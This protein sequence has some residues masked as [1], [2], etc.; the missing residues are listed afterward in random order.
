[1]LSW[2]V[3]YRASFAIDLLFGLRYEHRKNVDPPQS[4][5]ARYTLFPV[6]PFDIL[7]G[8]YRASVFS[9]EFSPTISGAFF[10]NV[11]RRG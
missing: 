10:R 5:P 8:I 3:S 2:R 6:T 4:L 11:P 9:K 1:M 7:F